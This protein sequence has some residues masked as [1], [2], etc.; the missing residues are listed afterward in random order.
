MRTLAHD[1]R[2]VSFVP[3]EMVL[4]SDVR[5]KQKLVIELLAHGASPNGGP[6]CKTTPVQLALDG[7]DFKMAAHLLQHGAETSQILARGEMFD[8]S[9]VTYHLITSYS[10]FCNIIIAWKD[11]N[12]ITIFPAFSWS[13]FIKRGIYF[14]K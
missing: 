7:Q 10:I 2:K 1:V 8:A 3:L 6:N 11:H 9:E 12:Q 5:D 13:K 4:Q 14:S